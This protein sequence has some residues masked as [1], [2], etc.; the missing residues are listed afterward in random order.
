M[1]FCSISTTA[2]IKAN[3]DL[4]GKW[5]GPNMQLEFFADQHVSL[6]LPGGRLPMATFSADYMRNP[7]FVTI[8][9]VDNGQK[10]IYKANLE[11]IDNENIQVEYISGD[12]NH[13]FEKGKILKLKKLK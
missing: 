13:Q 9:L 5:Q 8:T 10:L 7:I 4:I 3:R 1:F 11:F 12:V 2:Q 6:T